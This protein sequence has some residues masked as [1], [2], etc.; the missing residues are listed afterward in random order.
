MDQMNRLMGRKEKGLVVDFGDNYNG[1]TFKVTK[2]II[3]K[4][5]AALTIIDVDE[6]FSPFEL[7]LTHKGEWVTL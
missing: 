7:T 3:E 5:T 2:L 1:P 6:E 4:E